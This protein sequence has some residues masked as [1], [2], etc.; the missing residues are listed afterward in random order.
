MEIKRE[1]KNKS[2]KIVGRGGVRGKT[3]GRG[4][5]GQ[6]QHGGTPRPAMRDILKKLPKLRGYKFNSIKKK[7]LVVNLS[8]LNAVYTNGETVNI[9]TLFEKN[10][11][12]GNK[13]RNAEV[14]I[15]AT[16]DLSKKLTIEHC[17]VSEAARVK[18]TAAGGTVTE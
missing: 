7:P 10:I 13:A 14:K 4:H 9:T 8:E 1:H 11:F 17:L 2:K 5:K 15:L 3:S 6:K 12:K 18:I 16:G